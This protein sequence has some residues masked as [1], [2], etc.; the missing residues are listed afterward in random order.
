MAKDTLNGLNVTT[1]D[2]FVNNAISP[3]VS[4]VSDM[5]TFQTKDCSDIMVVNVYSAISLADTFMDLAGK[6]GNT[7]PKM[8]YGATNIAVDRYTRSFANS[9]ASTSGMTFNIVVVGTTDT[10]A[11]A[12]VKELKGFINSK[13]EVAPEAPEGPD[14][15]ACIVMLLA[16]EE[17]R[18]VTALP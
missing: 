7:G 12:A 1:I 17:E 8:A 9:F 6:T 2:I 15:I 5:K 14:N 10:E 3:D 4:K 16:S 11:L 13:V 18:W